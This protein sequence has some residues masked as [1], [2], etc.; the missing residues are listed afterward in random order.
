LLDRE[1]NVHGNH[2]E[3]ELVLEKQVDTGGVVIH[4][5]FTLGDLLYLGAMLAALREQVPDLPI[6]VVVGAI[7]RDFPF[8]EGIGVRRVQLPVPWDDRRWY[9]RP[10]HMLKGLPRAALGIRSLAKGS[11]LA[12]ARGDLRHLA[13]ATLAGRRSVS[14]LSLSSWERLWGR[15]PTHIF[16]ERRNWLWKL[17]DELG[18]PRTDPKW[19]WINVPLAS[20]KD[21]TATPT[22]VLSY[23]GAGELRKWDPD[24]WLRLVSI[25]RGQGFQCVFVHEPGRKPSALDTEDEW[26]GNIEQ[27]A[28]LLA[29]A[30]LVVAIDSFVGHLAAAVGAPTLTIFGPQ[31]PE[32]WTPWGPHA[33]YVIAEPFSCRPCTQKRC[34][35]PGASCMDLLDVRVVA[36]AVESFFATPA[37][38]T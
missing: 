2:K 21:A 16:L 15:A 30:D 18:L 22:I 8:F 12:D 35:R 38:I 34:V 6:S 32:L 19:P 10:I 14:N 20:P 25:L 33:R 4:D 29:S 24:K 11:L 26:R 17:Q 28:S 37:A 1:R 7:G 9:K 3:S 31:L 36:D 27:L 5:S 13:V 23:G